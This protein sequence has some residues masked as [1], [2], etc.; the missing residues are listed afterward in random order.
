MTS[1]LR[2]TVRREEAVLIRVLGLIVRRGFEP[3]RIIAAPTDEGH[4]IAVAVTV[5]GERDVDVLVRQLRRL[6]E[7]QRVEVI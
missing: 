4:A 2:M 7:I 5:E 3:V 6:D 1:E